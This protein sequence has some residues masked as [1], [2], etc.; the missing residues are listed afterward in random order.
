MHSEQFYVYIL[1]NQHHNVFYTGVTN[2]LIRR[3]YEHK[4]KIIKGFSYRYN[5]DKLIYY[6]IHTSIELAIHKEKL[7]KRWRRDI[8]CEAINTL[9]PHW[10][11][12]Y[13]DITETSG[14][15]VTSTG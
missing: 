9:N 10:R 11:D 7:V 12:L 8:K 15:P 13:F 6:E 14:D 5:V 3:V 4:N 1:C 2:N